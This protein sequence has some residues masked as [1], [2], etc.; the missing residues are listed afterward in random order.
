MIAALPTNAPVEVT[1]AG[2][3]V[4]EDPPCSRRLNATATHANGPA[5]GTPP[6]PAPPSH[7]NNRVD[8]PETTPPATGVAVIAGTD[9]AGAAAAA[10]T[11]TA[12]DTDTPVA[13]RATAAAGA[14]TG[15]RD[16]PELLVAEAFSTTGTVATVAKVGAPTGADTSGDGDAESGAAGT[17][18]LSPTD[19]CPE[20]EAEPERPCGRSDVG[21][22]GPSPLESPWPWDGV[23]SWAPPV[24]RAG[25]LA[26]VEGPGFD[27]SAALDPDDPPDPRVS[28]NAS[29]TASAA[30]PTPRAIASAPTRP[31]Q[32]AKPSALAGTAS[33]R[34]RS[35]ITPGRGFAERTSRSPDWREPAAFMRRSPKELTR[36]KPTLQGILVAPTG[37]CPPKRQNRGKIDPTILMV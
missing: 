1:A 4:V 34:R 6:S 2:L 18:F 13:G 27:E 7:S 8:R 3:P 29:G 28:A 25:A 24:R 21:T 30:E 10:D 32:R 31:T 14:G 36:T 33:A 22:V 26:L 23:G 19:S 11:T 12:A 16:E 5:A 20:R 17:E 15:K 35:S 37:T 9:A